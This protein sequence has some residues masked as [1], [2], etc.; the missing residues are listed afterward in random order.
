MNGPLVEYKQLEYNVYLQ[1][2][3]ANVAF[4]VNRCIKHANS[5]KSCI[6]TSME[7]KQTVCLQMNTD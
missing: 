2:K 7:F 4:L 5:W 3:V 1:R 6:F